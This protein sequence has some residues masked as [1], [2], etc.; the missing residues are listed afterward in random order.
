[1]LKT[2][3]AFLAIAILTVLVLALTKP[4][5]FRI[6]RQTSIAAP[7]AKVFALINDFHQ[8]QS[9]SPWEKKD[10]A[11]QR[12]HSGAASGKGAA[13][14]WS[15]NKNVGSGRMEITE[16]VPSSR[17]V[18]KLDFITPFEGHNTAEFTLQPQGEGTSVRWAMYGP[19]PFVSKLMQVFFSF[20]KMIG[21]DFEYGLA[22]LKALAE[23][24]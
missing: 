10:P 8:W 13:Y 4:D 21:P 5:S 14:A 20:E 15:G 2:I 19:T 6:E 7:P 22:S 3:A 11:M 24:P 18:I 12:S 16:S 1:M 17:V 9:W 23:R